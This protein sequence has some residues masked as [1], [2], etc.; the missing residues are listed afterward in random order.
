MLSLKLGRRGLLLVGKCGTKIDMVD[1]S[2]SVYLVLVAMVEW[3]DVLFVAVALL[4]QDVEVHHCSSGRAGRCK[5]HVVDVLNPMAM[6][7]VIDV[8]SHSIDEEATAMVV[9]RFTLSLMFN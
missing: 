6:Y 3:E 5:S 7:S 2:T 1:V 9:Q 4:L 8:E